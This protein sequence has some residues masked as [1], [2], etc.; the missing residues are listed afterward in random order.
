[1][2]QCK[3][4]TRTPVRLTRAATCIQ[5][6]RSTTDPRRCFQGAWSRTES[7]SLILVD[8]RG[9]HKILDEVCRH[10][11]SGRSSSFLFVGCT[12]AMR[13]IYQR[14]R[15]L[16]KVGS[17]RIGICKNPRVSFLALPKDKGLSI[18]L[19]ESPA[20]VSARKRGKESTTIS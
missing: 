12:T 14:S 5:H 15:Y 1:M 10:V 4:L 13:E 20:L 11:D 16:S 3:S 2:E 19:R 18:S 17:R 6:S 9:V 7:I 8:S